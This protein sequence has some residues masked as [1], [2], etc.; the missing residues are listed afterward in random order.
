MGE[1]TEQYLSIFVFGLKS[2]YSVLCIVIISIEGK[3]V[4]LLSE[5]YENSPL[6]FFFSVNKIC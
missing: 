2:L 5:W 4:Y 6:V 3:N 1:I